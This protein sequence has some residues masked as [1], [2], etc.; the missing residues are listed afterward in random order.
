MFLNLGL[1]FT[2]L[3]HLCLYIFNHE[4]VDF[5]YWQLQY[6]SKTRCWAYFLQL[7][8]SIFPQNWHTFKAK[9]SHSCWSS[10]CSLFVVFVVFKDIRRHYLDWIFWCDSISYHIAGAPSENVLSLWL[11]PGS[12]TLPAQVYHTEGLSTFRSRLKLHPLLFTQYTFSLSKTI[13]YGL[14][15]TKVTSCFWVKTGTF[16]VMIRFGVQFMVQKLC[17]SMWYAK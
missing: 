16:G 3:P 1:P 15:W 17:C 6:H 9:V 5:D 14:S 8:C 10:P 2:G 11:D 4:F 13:N 7:R 12:G